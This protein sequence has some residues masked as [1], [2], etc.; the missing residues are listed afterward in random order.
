MKNN[1]TENTQHPS[2]EQVT[3]NSNNNNNDS[4]RPSTT[5]RL[6]REPSSVAIEEPSVLQ[7]ADLVSKLNGKS[8]H[9][10]PYL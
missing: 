7:G 3:S 2:E 1:N 4:D 10:S 6:E 8:I 9:Q 5:V